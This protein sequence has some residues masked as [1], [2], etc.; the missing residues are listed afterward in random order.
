MLHFRPRLVSL[1]LL[2]VALAPAAFGIEI[3]SNQVTLQTGIEVGGVGETDSAS[4]SSPGLVVV[5]T[6]AGNSPSNN[7]AVARSN[8]FAPDD[9]SLTFTANSSVTLR[10]A[11]SAAAAVNGYARTE[12]RQI[13]AFL[14]PEE[15]V[16]IDY[17]YRSILNI[18]NEPT[19]NNSFTNFSLTIGAGTRQLFRLQR[20]SASEE[21]DI[22]GTLVI[23]D[24]LGLNPG[25]QIT[26]I[27]D[28]QSYGYIDGASLFGDVDSDV[29]LDITT[30]PEP[31][32][33]ALLLAA[34]PALLARRRRVG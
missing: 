32:S 21:F 1:A 3:V 4:T 13:F 29:R 2:V 5:R 15:G 6:A 8:L 26:V 27:V 28:N 9:D 11:D 16:T 23:D 22:T 10:R 34:A 25:A 19:A 31:A 12:P 18:Q 14:L 20:S 30:I 33:L 7:L 17:A 24:S